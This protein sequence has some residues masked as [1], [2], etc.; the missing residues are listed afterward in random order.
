MESRTIKVRNIS[1]D[2]NIDELE[3]LFNKFGLVNKVTFICDKYNG[4]F[5]GYK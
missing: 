4:E 2:C 3:I 1:T 5:K